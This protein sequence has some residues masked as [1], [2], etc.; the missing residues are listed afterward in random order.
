MCYNNEE[1]YK[2]WKETDLPVQNWHKEFDKFW[3]EHS[4]IWK[5]CTL[6][7][8]FWPKYVML[9]LRNYRRVMFDCTQNWYKVWRKTDLHFQKWHEELNKF[10]PEHLEV[11]KLGP[12]WRPFVQSWKCV[13]LKFTGKLRVMIMKNDAKFEEELTRQFKIDMKNLTTFDLSTQKSKKFVLQWA[14]FDQSI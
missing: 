1:W 3:P 13:S 11:S 4:K 6:M 12:S 7:D 14:A 9:E 5:I 2:I 10:L 8:C